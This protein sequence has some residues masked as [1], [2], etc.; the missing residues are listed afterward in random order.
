MSTRRSRSEQEW[1]VL[2]S[3]SRELTTRVPELAD[4]LLAELDAHSPAYAVAV[5]RDEHWRE[6]C[7]ALRHGIDALTASRSAP[8]PD[9]AY[10]AELGR[11]R[12]EQGISLDLLLYAFRRAGY[13]LWNELTDTVSA[14]D[15]AALSLLGRTAVTVWAGVD[16]QATKA[17]DAYR[18]TERELLRRTDERVQALLDALLAGQRDAALVRRASAALDL[19]EQGRYAVLVLR[20]EDRAPARVAD[21]DGLRFLWRMRTDGEVGVVALGESAGLADLVGCVAARRGGPG[22]ISTVVGGLAELGRARRQAELALGTLPA[23][24]AGLVRLDR[25]LPAALVTAQPELAGLLVEDVFGGLDA[26]E[27]ADR[28]VLLETL[29]TWLECGGSAAR[30]ATRLYCH[31]NTVFNRLR[32]LEQLTERSLSRPRDLVEMTLALDAGRPPQGKP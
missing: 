13:L 6:I 1:A 22:G 30:A 29:E 25:C 4:L 27:A 17:A 31:R 14:R 19:P 7:E 28:S 15:P 21:G 10:V 26:L 16:D 11:R 2:A 24:A 18:A 23:G 5:P 12:A 20:A 9:L 8:R 32:R 3:A